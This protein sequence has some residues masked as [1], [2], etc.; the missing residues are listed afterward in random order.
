MENISAVSDLTALRSRLATLEGRAGAWSDGV[1][2]RPDAPVPGRVAAAVL[3]DIYAETPADGSAANAFALGLATGLAEGRAIVWA[4]QIM[5]ANEGGDPSGAGLNELGI[6]PGRIVLVRVKDAP[7]L[8]GVGEEALG[9]PA[10]GAVVLSAWGEAKAFSLTASR[11]LSL[12]A[13]KGGGTVF[14]T[15]IAAEPSPGAAET[16]WR[17][18]SALSSPLEAGAPGRPRVA[19]TLTRHRGGA[20][21]KTWIMEWDRETRSFIDAAP[22]SC[23]VVSV[24]ADRTSGAGGERRRRAG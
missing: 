23:A 13:G 24:P 3:H 14:L 7:A 18:R 8:L 5:A 2:M 1:E 16:R 17:V 22:L 19:A 11:R 4:I 9:N 21:L 20:Q 6:D 10:V 12:A 15:R